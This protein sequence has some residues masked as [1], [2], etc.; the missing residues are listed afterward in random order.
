MS[1]CRKVVI[2]GVGLIGGSLAAALKENRF[3]D[4]IVGAGRT[5]ANLEKA[6]EL[7]CIDRAATD[8]EA[9]LADADIVVAATPVTTIK[10]VFEA[11][12]SADVRD[13]IVTD[14]ASVKGSVV[15]FALAAFGADFPNFVPAHP[16]AGREHSGVTAAIASLYQGKRTILTPLPYTDADAVERV[17]GM[18]EAAG[19]AV[20]Q[21]TVAN[22]DTL[23]AASSHLPHMVAFALVNYIAEHSRSQECFDLAASGF[24]DFTRIASSD[25]VMWHDICMTN[26]AAVADELEGYVRQLESLVELVRER[27]SN[28]L[29]SALQS[30]KA[31]RDTNLENWLKAVPKQ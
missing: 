19:S 24:Y 27:Q 15:E 31:A 14:V 21:M 3:A 2:Y 1:M 22:H 13:C 16:I 12:A 20:S 10:K 6:L 4:E 23:L 17:T 25:P 26:S 18:W 5:R 28:R 29:V 9:E 8:F 30:A 11:I 7:D